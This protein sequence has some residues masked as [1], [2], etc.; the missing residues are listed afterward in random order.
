MVGRTISAS[1]LSLGISLG[2]VSQA[3]FIAI[4]R[5]TLNAKSLKARLAL[6]LECVIC[7]TCCVGENVSMV[8]GVGELLCRCR[9]SC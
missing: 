4:H 1:P 9:Q 7:N 2:I 3:V 6:R 5:L 8:A